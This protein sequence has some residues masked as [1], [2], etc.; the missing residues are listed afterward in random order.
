MNWPWKK[1]ETEL[2][3]EM[4]YHLDSLVDGMEEQI[5]ETLR[6]E[7][8]FAW[9]CGAFGVLALALCMIGLYGV[10]SYVT[11]RRSQ[12]IG[13]RMALSAHR[14]VT[15]CAILVGEGM[16]LAIGGLLVGAPAAWWAAQKYVD[17]K[18]L[19]MEPLDP[20]ILGGSGE[21][22]TRGL[23]GKCSATDRELDAKCA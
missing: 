14:P 8:L 4:R 12:E 9:L 1:A 21:G 20:A 2:E 13:I 7:R 18:K 22:V 16:S 3:R 5:S 11:S 10:M 17:Y 19:G 6:R 23:R 15:S